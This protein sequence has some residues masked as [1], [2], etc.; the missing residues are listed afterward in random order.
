M[1]E[2]TN[3]LNDHAHMRIRTSIRSDHGASK[4][5]SG[6][7]TNMRWEALLKPRVASLPPS[8]S[9]NLYSKTPQP[10]SHFSS[11]F[12]NSLSLSL[13]H[14]VTLS[15]LI[16]HFSYLSPQAISYST[17]HRSATSEAPTTT[18][19][20]VTCVVTCLVTCSMVLLL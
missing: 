2:P 7:R 15:P 20:R 3:T 19:A 5:V 9:S 12:Q 1:N 10:A 6:W 16:F 11:A 18:M 13:S 14:P 4:Y 17:I 8:S